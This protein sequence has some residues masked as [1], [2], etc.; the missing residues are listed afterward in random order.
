MDLLIQKVADKMGENRGTGQLVGK[1]TLGLAHVSSGVGRGDSDQEDRRALEPSA[2]QSEAW[3]RSAGKIE[4]K[5][6]R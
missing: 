5:R 1:F 4:E 2:A 6:N 3:D